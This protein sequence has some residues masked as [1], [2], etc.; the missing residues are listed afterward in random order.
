MDY[1]VY[2]ILLARIL[3]WVAFPF[4]RG[5]SQ[6]RDWTQVSRIAGGFLA[7]WTTREACEAP[8]Q[9]LYS[10]SA[11]ISKWFNV[12]RFSMYPKLRIAWIPLWV[13]KQEAVEN[14]STTLLVHFALYPSEWMHG[15]WRKDCFWSTSLGWHLCCRSQETYM[16]IVSFLVWGWMI[17]QEL[18]TGWEKMK[19]GDFYPKELSSSVTQSCLTLCNPMPGFPVHPQLLELAQSHVHWAGDAKELIGS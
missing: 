14:V 6:L 3:K 13:W 17:S 19:E 9:P 16:G 18:M 1:T 8:S 15:T 7:S 12:K 5:S 10:G 4:S 2:G 11:V